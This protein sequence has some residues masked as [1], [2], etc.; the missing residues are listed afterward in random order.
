MTHKELLQTARYAGQQHEPDRLD[1]RI[2]LEIRKSKTVE[3][4][5]LMRRF[6][7]EPVGH[8]Y[9]RIERLVHGGL[10]QQ[11]MDGA[12]RMLRIT[13]IAQDVTA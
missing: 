6:S 9:R 2:L 11:E 13:P 4:Y 12:Y 3:R 10:V 7:D 5:D 1:A 8:L